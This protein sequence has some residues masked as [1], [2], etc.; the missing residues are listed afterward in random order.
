MSICKYSNLNQERKQR[1]YFIK[2]W[3]FLLCCLKV[4]IVFEE[5]ETKAGHGL[6]K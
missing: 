4:K 1:L 6:L 5:K 3:Q 2:Y